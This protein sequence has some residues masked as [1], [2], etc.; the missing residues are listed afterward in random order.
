[1]NWRIIDKEINKYI[2][3]NLLPNMIAFTFNYI[4]NTNLP[5]NESYITLYNTIKT[6]INIVGENEYLVYKLVID[7]LKNK[8][9]LTVINLNPLVLKKINLF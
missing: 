9:H 5:I 2:E 1:M 8:Y 4:Y 7:I 6:Y 3:Y